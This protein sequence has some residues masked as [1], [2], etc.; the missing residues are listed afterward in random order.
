M[1]TEKQKKAKQY[2]KQAYRCNEL[3][4]NSLDEIESLRAMST[5][6]ASPNWTKEK[7]S[8]THSHEAHYVNVVTKLIDLEKTVDDE[9]VH[10]LDLKSAIRET[11]N[12]VEDVKGILVLRY[13]YLDFMKWE[14]LC[15]KMGYSM[16]Q[17]HRIH[18]TALNS[19]ADALN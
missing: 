11:I 12:Q 18:K 14:D 9:M 6:I 8:C 7:V 3:L 5:S 4:K 16:R 15:E 17:V 13:R 10:L 2:L 19:L 1:L